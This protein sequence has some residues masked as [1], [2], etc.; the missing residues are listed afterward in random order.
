[1]IKVDAEFLLRVSRRERRAVAQAITLIESS[2]QDHQKNAALMQNK[3]LQDP[4]SK[5]NQSIR[6][7]VSGVP[8]VGKSSFV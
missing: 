8:G 7:G 3:I 4:S 6:I 2:N 5:V 1:M